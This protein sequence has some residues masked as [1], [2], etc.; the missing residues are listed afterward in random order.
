MEGSRHC[1]IWGTTL[2]FAWIGSGDRRNPPRTV[3][4]WAKIWKQNTRQEYWPLNNNVRFLSSCVCA[5]FLSTLLISAL[6]A[7][8]YSWL[9]LHHRYILCERIFNTPCIVTILA[10]I[11]NYNTLG[12]LRLVRIESLYFKYVIVGED[13]SDEFYET[14]NCRC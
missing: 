10:T 3:G 1:L 11:Q 5:G 4:L 8:M 14:Y 6:S 12:R 2:T 13:I 7:P 9:R